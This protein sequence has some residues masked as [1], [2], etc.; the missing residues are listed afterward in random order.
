MLEKYLEGEILFNI[1]NIIN[2]ISNWQED[3]DKTKAI[4]N[5]TE[6]DIN[7][8]C[9]RML[10]SGW[11]V[12]ELNEFINENIEGELYHYIEGQKNE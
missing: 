2:D 1:E 8:I 12:T 4:E 7:I 10:N 9:N 6:N 5:L 11:F 3:Y